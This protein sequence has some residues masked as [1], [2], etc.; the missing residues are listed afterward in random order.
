MANS[1]VGFAN[2]ALSVVSLASCP[3]REQC[4]G[5]QTT[6]AAHNGCVDPDCNSFI[7]LELDPESR[8]CKL[9]GYF[10]Y[11]S[12]VCLT[13][14]VVVEIALQEAKIRYI[15][16]ALAAIKPTIKID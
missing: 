10:F 6:S 5:G 1:Q 9:R 12:A 2:K 15:N 14:F 13:V 11:V 8:T 4:V 7:L 3:L 16:A